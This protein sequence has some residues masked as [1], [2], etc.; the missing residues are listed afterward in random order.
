M[1]TQKYRA[2]I[3]SVDLGSFSAAAEEMRFTPSGISHMV[4]AVENE[5]GCEL[6]K[7]GRNGVSLNPS[8]EIM[9]PAIRALINA[10]TAI[11]QESS[12]LTGLAKGSITI[13]AYSSIAAQWLPQ[14]LRNFQDD[15]PGISVQL[16]EGVHEELDDWMA[17][18]RMD[19]CL[20]S[21]RKGLEFEWIPLRDDQMFLVVSPDHPF[22]SKAKS[23]RKNVRASR[24]S[25][26]DAT[27][28]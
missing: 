18:D 14:I 15:Y 20:F 9:M 12:A 16:M 13:G 22:A 25:C 1:D 10:E 28:I 27:T 6:L 3:R 24:L 7:R 23:N 2:F 8:G 11:E 17:A 21:Y 5:V 19:F 4:S 26:R